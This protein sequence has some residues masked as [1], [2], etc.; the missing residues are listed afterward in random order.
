MNNDRTRLGTGIVISVAINTFVLVPG[1]TADH[2][3]MAWLPDEEAAVQP[4]EFTPEP[5]EPEVKLGI[6]ESEAST[7]TWIGYEEFQEHMARLA[8]LEQAQFELAG[9]SSGG[10]GSPPAQ[11]TDPSTP[12]EEESLVEA[13]TAQSPTPETDAPLDSQP[14]LNP[15]L[16]VMVDGAR[17]SIQDDTALPPEQQQ[18]EQKKP[19]P[20]SEA[21]TTNTTSTPVSKTSPQEVVETQPGSP[22]KTPG[23]IVDG[24]EEIPPKPNASDTEADAATMIQVN[25]KR[26]GGPVA[27][28]G[29][30][31]RTIRPKLTPYQETRFGGIAIKVKIEFS[32]SGAP[33]RVYIARQH[34]KTGKILW[35]PATGTVGFESAI[36]SALFRWRASGEQLNTLQKGETLPVLFELIYR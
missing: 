15:E 34:P 16:P 17:P 33:K 22:D 24:L 4:P 28:K 32:K 23:P 6:D 14:P 29:L 3:S 7:L 19:D 5:D 25:V 31:V 30:R 26:Q 20:T 10:G 18:P 13:D 11:V 9:K 12:S 36:V 35:E 1:L 21:T 8:E 2:H 27:A